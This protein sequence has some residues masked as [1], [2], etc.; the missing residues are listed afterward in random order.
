MP[1]PTKASKAAKPRN[2]AIDSSFAR[3]DSR[4]FAPIYCAE[5]FFSGP[6]PCDCPVGP[7]VLAV[8]STADEVSVGGARGG[9]KTTSMFAFL[10]KGNNSRGFQK[11]PREGYPIYRQG[12]QGTDLS[13][14]VNRNYR[15]LLL[16][17]QASDMGYILDKAEEF[18]APIHPELTRGTPAEI[19]FPSGAK[20]LCGHFGEDGWKKYL[21]PEFVRI[22]I[23]QIEK[24]PLRETYDR[25]K[26]SARVSRWP[27]MKAQVFSTWNPGG[28][29]DL[30]GAPGQ[31]WIMDYFMVDAYLDG[32]LKPYQYVRDPQSGKT[33]HFVF[34]KVM[35]N[36]FFRFKMERKPDG[37]RQVWMWQCDPA[38][39]GCGHKY[40]AADPEERCPRCG[41]VD[42]VV[43]QEVA[44]V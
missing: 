27:E 2:L 5:H 40:E 8:N 7:Q 3:P 4:T 26:S 22:A 10:S 23:D 37:F 31:G 11:A 43:M 18:W 17:E 15:A 21:G 34:S 30:K 29:D 9:T 19:K 35:D 24:M 6:W 32:R 12:L 14:L 33:K 41:K 16:I 25:I 1:P 20:I 39:G 42:E 28:G 13:Y 44:V 36:P 38:E